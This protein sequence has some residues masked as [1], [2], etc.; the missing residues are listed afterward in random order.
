MCE[1]CCGD[2][3]HALHGIA[4]I[5]HGGMSEASFEERRGQLVHEVEVDG[6]LLVP[7][8][9][10]THGGGRVWVGCPADRDPGAVAS[11]PLPTRRASAVTRA[12]R[13]PP[14]AARCGR[15]TS[16]VRLFW[17]MWVGYEPSVHSCSVRSWKV[18]TF[19][20]LVK[21]H[22]GPTRAA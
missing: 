6:P 15:I 7:G 21:N 19:S 10:G 16:I 5:L 3:V 20:A 1:G 17:S 11:R 8:T 14:G 18:V 2:V 12:D 4:S 9:R 22:Y 13:A